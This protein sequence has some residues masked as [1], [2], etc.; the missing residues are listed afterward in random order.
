MGLEQA[1]D[2]PT[3]CGDGAFEKA[4]A[5]MKIKMFWG[6]YVILGIEHLLV[7]VAVQTGG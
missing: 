6:A 5:E 2:S 7:C 1:S 3:S 4:I